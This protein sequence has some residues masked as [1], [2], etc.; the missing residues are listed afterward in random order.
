MFMNQFSELHWEPETDKLSQI[1]VMHE[2]QCL[3]ILSRIQITKSILLESL[4]YKLNIVPLNSRHEKHM[5]KI[6]YDFIWNGVDQISRIK[7]EQTLEN[8]GL[9]LDRHST[10]A[11]AAMAINIFRLSNPDN[12]PIGA[13]LFK[14]E[15]NNLGGVRLLQGKPDTTLIDAISLGN[16]KIIVQSY[17]SILPTP[18]TAFG[19]LSSVHGSVHSFGTFPYHKELATNGFIFVSDFYN[20]NGSPLSTSYRLRLGLSPNA[21][22]AFYGV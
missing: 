5:S 22:L 12:K 7:A 14:S 19:H 2:S 3:S 11:N 9:C 4:Q 17:S 15:L 1:Y 18:E 13:K 10:R 20:K 6:I 16:I 8:G 21:Q